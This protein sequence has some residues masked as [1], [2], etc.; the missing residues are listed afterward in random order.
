[1]F[2]AITCLAAPADLDSINT[3]SAFPL[4]VAQDELLLLGTPDRAEHVAAVVG[5]QLPGDAIV[6][7]DTDSFTAWTIAGD[8]SSEAFS[9]LSAIPLD[10]APTACVRQGL[11]AGVPAK[12]VRE[13]SAI[14]IFVSSVVGHHL[15]ECIK[16]ACADLEVCEDEALAFDASNDAEVSV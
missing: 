11:V 4:R 13:S 6:A 2:S 5:D 15:H 7:V 10:S 3:R 12:I 9:R 16:K 1:M 8:E 14:H